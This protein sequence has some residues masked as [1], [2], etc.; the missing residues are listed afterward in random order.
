VHKDI[1]MWLTIFN[2]I[3]F[4]GH[5][6]TNG[7][8]TTI[9]TNAETTAELDPNKDSTWQWP[10]FKPDTFIDPHFWVRITSI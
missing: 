3:N 4:K 5:S 2:L 10:K 9:K 8:N 7:E 6:L 1:Y